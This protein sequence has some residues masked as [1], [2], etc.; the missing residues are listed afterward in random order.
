[1]TIRRSWRDGRVDRVV[2]RIPIDQ[3]CAAQ[4]R[5]RAARWHAWLKDSKCTLQDRK[6]FERWYSDVAN[7]AAYDALCHE[8]AAAGDVAEG[9]AALLCALSLPVRQPRFEANDC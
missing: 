1:M 3:A 6:N 5:R 8:L 9:T 4:A 2:T 7:A